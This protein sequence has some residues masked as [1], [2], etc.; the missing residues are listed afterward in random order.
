MP[1]VI[2]SMRP[3]NQK[4]LVDHSTGDALGIREE[5][6][7]PVDGVVHPATGGM[8][9]VPTIA[10]VPKHL[11]PV[12]L[13]G[14]YPGARSYRKDILPWQ[15]GQGPF[16]NGPLFPRLDLRL[17]PKNAK[18]GLVEPAESMLL[19]DFRVAVETTC[20]CWVKMEW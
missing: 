7:K 4:P 6:V 14:K 13:K 20:D 8:S 10:D 12:K 5:D 3:D 9:V 11:I 17:D 15:L 2:R 1:Y 19:S 16:A 18:H